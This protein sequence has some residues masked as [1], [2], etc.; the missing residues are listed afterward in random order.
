MIQE[1]H[2]SSDITPKNLLILASYADNGAARSD[3]SKSSDTG[4]RDVASLLCTPANNESNGGTAFQNDIV[5]EVPFEPRHIPD[6][7]WTWY[8]TNS[9]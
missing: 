3:A 4:N 8:R 7:P 5:P 6:S 2:I 9:R 1:E